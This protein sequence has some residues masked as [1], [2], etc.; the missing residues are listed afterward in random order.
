MKQQIACSGGIVSGGACYCP[1]GTTLNAG[2]CGQ[3]PAQ[4]KPVAVCTNTAT[5]MSCVGACQQ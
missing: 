1:V 2:A 5:S 3:V 4:C